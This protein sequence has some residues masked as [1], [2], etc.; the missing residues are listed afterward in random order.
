ML[1]EGRKEEGGFRPC[2]RDRGSVEEGLGTR[3]PAVGRT[4]QEVDEAG[5]MEAEVHGELGQRWA[6]HGRGR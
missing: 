5:A 6:G 3:Q 4:R 2:L 1:P